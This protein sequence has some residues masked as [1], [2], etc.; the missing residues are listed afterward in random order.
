MALRWMAN[1]SLRSLAYRLT[2]HNLI[3]P[4]PE[5]ARMHPAGLTVSPSLAPSCHASVR[6]TSGASSNGGR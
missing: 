3:S 1:T 4:S 6:A 5:L 2:S